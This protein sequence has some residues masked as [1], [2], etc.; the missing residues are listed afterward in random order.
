M[1]DTLAR[2]MASSFGDMIFLVCATLMPAVFGCGAL[3]CVRKSTRS[4]EAPQ[5]GWLALLTLLAG[6]AFVLCLLFS[7]LLLGAEGYY[8]IVYDTTDGLNQTRV[9]RR[10][11]DRYWVLNNINV[12]DNLDYALKREAG[13]PRLT[14]LGDSFT[15]AQGVKN[16]EDRF[17]NIIRRERPSWEVHSI[18]RLGI[19]TPGQLAAI[20]TLSD[21]GYE[22]DLV[23][24]AYCWNDILP[25][26]DGL[27]PF[28]EAINEPRPDAAAFWIDHSLAINAAFHRYRVNREIRLLGAELSDAFETAYAGDPWN[29]QRM[30]LQ[31][32]KERVELAG[33]RLA[34]VT[35]P[36]LHPLSQGEVSLEIMHERLGA[37]WAGL[38]VPYLDLLPTLRAHMGPQLIVNSRDDHPSEFTHR[39]A[40]DAMLPFL[41]PLVS[42]PAS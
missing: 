25:L 8:R 40:A 21:L 3:L 39:L 12:R 22:F 26:I 11:F 31:Q 9:S 19:D 10:W 2:L 1:P 6:N 5:H 32:L 27:T 35:F 17:L 36:R 18:A 29:T 24:L 20:S 13:R 14:I 16:V 38:D 33:G 4:G 42:R 41:D 34:V 30:H 7:L 28:F 37:I 23:V 15:A